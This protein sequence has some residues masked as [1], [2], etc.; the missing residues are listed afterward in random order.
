MKYFSGLAKFCAEN[1]DKKVAFV[2]KPAKIKNH[3]KDP[4]ANQPKLS[5]FMHANN[6]QREKPFLRSSS[7]LTKYVPAQSQKFETESD[8]ID[9]TKNMKPGEKL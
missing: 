2:K 8:V 3:P 6:I 1:T 9:V 4:P 5:E 7:Q